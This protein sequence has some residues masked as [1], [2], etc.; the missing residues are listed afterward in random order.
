MQKLLHCLP[1]QLLISIGFLVFLTGLNAQ[2]SDSAK[3]IQL[4]SDLAELRSLIVQRDSN[5][6]EQTREN[7]MNGFHNS[8]VLYER[9]EYRKKEIG[10]QQHSIR[11]LNLN[12]P[13]TAQMVKQFED[14]MKRL[15]NEKLSSI[16]NTDTFKRKKIFRTLENIFQNPIIAP[17]LNSNPISSA[18][19][20]AYNF[21]S[22]LVEPQV[23][24]VR[25]S[26]GG[27]VKEVKVDL[28]NIVDNSLMKGLTSDLLPYI[29]FFDT[30]YII[31]SQ[32]ST[33]LNLLKQR[34]QTLAEGYERVWNYYRGLGI[35]LDQTPVKK[36]KLFETTF[37]S[38]IPA[39]SVAR[40]ANYLQDEKIKKGILYSKEV[41]NY[42]N[43]FNELTEDY[44]TAIRA[45]RDQYIGVLEKY[46]DRLTLYA[47]TLQQAYKE[48]TAEEPLV[49]QLIMSSGDVKDQPKVDP[50]ELK[51]SKAIWSF[52]TV[53]PEAK[54]ATEKIF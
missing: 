32:F 21:I 22:S 7:L 18:I 29:R 39:E 9:I 41:L 34:S 46:K 23:Q 48:L 14:F 10:D 30:L 26:V 37:P 5:D 52:N 43:S 36:Q 1:K 45:F 40:F 4:A 13:G 53:D 49:N 8:Y 51:A 16:I 17:I 2:V 27:L 28:N 54:K 42:Y 15:V 35:A 38:I 44:N 6:Y 33:R 11:L 25:S 19:S 47:S 12:N 24:V 31:N 50:L 3:L 20:S